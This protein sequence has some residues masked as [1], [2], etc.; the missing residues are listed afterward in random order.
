MQRG[1]AEK[2]TPALP[3]NTDNLVVLLMARPEIKTVSDLTNKII[4]IDDRH[5]ASNGSI[6]TAIGAAGA[7]EA[8][9]S[10]SQTKAIDR[11]ISGEV[12][13]AVLTVASQEAAEGFPDIA[14]FNIFRIPLSPR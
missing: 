11:V 6:R 8:Q 13:A 2:I 5:S 14:G 4:A 10:N 7:A 3:N 9:L 1:D 12:P